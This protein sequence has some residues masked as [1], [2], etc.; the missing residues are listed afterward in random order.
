M[1]PPVRKT[2]KRHPRR[3]PLVAAILSLLLLTAARPTAAQEWTRFRGPNGSGLAPAAPIP[4]S[5]TEADANWRVELPGPGNSQPVLWGGR[6]FVTSARKDGAERIIQCLGTEAGKAHWTKSLPAAT[7]SKHQR[8]TFATSTPAADAE[9]IYAAFSD[10]MSL[11]LRAFTHEGK[12]VWT[13]DL[14]AFE[15]KHG[16]GGSPIVFEEM[17]VLANEEDTDSFVIA[18]DRKTGETRWKSARR[19]EEAA[20]GTPCVFEPAGGPAE[21]ILSS[22]AHGLSSIDPRT[23]KENWSARVFDKRTVS[24]P[25]VAGSL[26]LATCGSGGGGNYLAAV[27]SGGKGDVTASHLAFKVTKAMPY[28]PSTLVKGDIVFLWGDVGVVS[29]VDAKNGEIIW[30][31]RAGGNFSGSPVCVG[32]RLYCLSEEGEAVVID[33]ARRFNLLGRSPL[34]EGTRSTPA[35]AGGRMY[36]RTYTHLISIGGKAD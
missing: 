20:Y 11:T 30:Q 21:L 27:R 25:V 32:E 19:T 26:I 33:A 29:C 28:V 16:G 14:G 5:W 3:I 22:H 12:E 31:A 9:R 34:G 23:G 2:T 24:S 4:V 13:R 10:P 17:V 6:I 1:T 18:L 15:S 7:H 8:N 36:I 35:V